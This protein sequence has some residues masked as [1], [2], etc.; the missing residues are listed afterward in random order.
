MCASI[1]VLFKGE[2]NNHWVPGM[3]KW[4]NNFM[5]VKNWDAETL[6]GI[7]ETLDTGLLLLLLLRKYFY[8]AYNTYFFYI[9][10]LFFVES[11]NYSQSVN[12]LELYQRP[13][14]IIYRV[15]GRFC[16]SVTF[17]FLILAI[18]NTEHFQTSIAIIYFYK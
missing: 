13:G 4:L 5:Y 17:C 3:L 11:L 7:W 15:I 16:I 1:F 14:S 18:I 8:F 10:G 2:N 9:C 6:S 12:T